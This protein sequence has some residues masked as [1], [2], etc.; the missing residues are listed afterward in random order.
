MN[1][2]TQKI[3]FS[4][5]VLVLGGAE[6]ALAVVRSISRAGGSVSACTN[7]VGVSHSRYLRNCH[8][9]HGE[10]SPE[11]LFG[12]LLLSDKSPYR[13]SVIFAAADDAVKF[14]AE[15]H[16]E[17]KKNF[18][19]EK[20]DPKIQLAMLD[21]QR[22]LELAK[23]TGI[24]TPKFWSVQTM[25][26]I[27]RLINDVPF[28]VLIK[29]MDTY[30]FKER[31]S[32]GSYVK[33]DNERELIVNAEKLIAQ[34]IDFMLTEKIPGLD[35]LGC[36]CY[37]YLLEDGNA[38]FTLSKKC[39]RRSPM[40]NGGGTFQITKKQLDVEEAGMRFFRGIGYLGFGNLEFKRDT[41]DGKIKV[42]E[43]NARFTAVQ[44][45]LT[46]SGVDVPVISYC[47][48]TGQQI[49][50][51]PECRESVGIWSPRSDLEAFREVRSA[52]GVSF[53]DWLYSLRASRM[54]FPYFALD[55]LGPSM[56][57]FMLR[58]KRDWR[59]LK[60]L[61]SLIF[62]LAKRDAQD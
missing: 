26:D 15:N 30:S 59:G 34:G 14:I 16:E 25:E 24:E 56:K 23:E 20:N 41:R 51:V 47:H 13:G 44:E 38:V 37:T 48:I 3:D 49:P 55:D 62:A 46:Q 50:K 21:K 45:Q 7:D 40:N 33:V 39:I 4:R 60:R 32:M 31:F 42:I 22:T 18:L 10:Q 35:D 28:P 29:P 11:Q 17:L 6:S 12:D 5:P 9:T 61:G 54:V 19:L 27:E 1:R 58:A 52:T 43:C 2:S 57:L 36:S 8:R 53:L